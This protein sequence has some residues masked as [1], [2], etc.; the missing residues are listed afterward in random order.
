M[1]ISELEGELKSLREQFGDLPVYNYHYH[2][3]GGCKT[4]VD[5]EIK[6]TQ[7]SYSNKI[8]RI[9]LRGDY[10]VHQ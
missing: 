2:I 3:S 5:V 6:S 1:L 9:L 10:S 8:P 7:P 4:I